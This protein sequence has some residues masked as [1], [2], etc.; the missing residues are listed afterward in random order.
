MNIILDTNVLVSGIFFKG[1]PF[2]ILLAWKNNKFKLV[3][4]HQIIEE[5]KRVINELSDQFPMINFSG[6]I[7]KIA[8][9]SVFS[10]SINLSEPI[11]TDPDDDKFFA[12]AIASKTKIIVSGDKHLH[13]KS[14]YAGIMVVK[15]IDFLRDHLSI[16]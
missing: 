6:I 9:N 4:T 1:P 8:L 12:A 15:P 14:G 3:T 16:Q 2:R 7:E 13:Y 10:L 5:Y 11:C